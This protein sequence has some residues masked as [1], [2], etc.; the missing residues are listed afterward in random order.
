MNNDSASRI[1]LSSEALS[2]IAAALPE[3]SGGLAHLLNLLAQDLAAS[4]E[5]IDARLPPP[6]AMPENE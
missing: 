4:G 1:L 2:F 5:E 3:S 6:S